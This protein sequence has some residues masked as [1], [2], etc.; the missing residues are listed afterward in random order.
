M[1]IRALREVGVDAPV[2]HRVGIGQGVARDAAA[3]A[4]VIELARLRSQTRFDVAQ[5]L[6][7]GQLRER[8]AQE[9]IEAGEAS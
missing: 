4:H 7:I 9:L 8:H 6:A 2:A 1:P 5:A 3:N